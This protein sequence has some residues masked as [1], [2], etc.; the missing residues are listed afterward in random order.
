MSFDNH[1]SWCYT[2]PIHLLHLLDQPELGSTLTAGDG[3]LM[4]LLHG[5]L[6]WME[7][8]SE[9]GRGEG[10]GREGGRDGEKEG[11]REKG[12]EEGGEEGKDINLCQVPGT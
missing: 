10:G 12:R 1:H 11:G 3:Y 6:G 8:G 5:R 4:L 2:C 9:G 7:G